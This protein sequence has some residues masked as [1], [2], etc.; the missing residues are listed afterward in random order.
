MLLNILSELTMLWAQSK[1]FLPSPG[2]GDRLLWC[3]KKKNA[4]FDAAHIFQA[5]LKSFFPQS[6][7]QACWISSLPQPS[8]VSSLFRVSRREYASHG[9][10]FLP[11]LPQTCPY[12]PLKTLR[13]ISQSSGGTSPPHSEPFPLP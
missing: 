2:K 11:H 7:Y 13:V 6:V 10:F 1:L 4:P 12:R 8:Q 3:L 9:I 5:G